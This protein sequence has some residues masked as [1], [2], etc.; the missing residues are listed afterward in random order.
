M[1]N[2]TSPL[3]VAIGAINWDV[4]LFVESLPTPGQEVTVKEVVR[5]PGGTAANVAVAAARLLEPNNVAF[6]GALGDDAIGVGQRAILQSEGVATDGITTIPDT[7]SG[8]AFILVD[9]N[10]QNV[11]ASAL[12]ANALL[13]ADHIRQP[14]VRNM[15][16]SARNCA[17]TDPP[18][19]VIEEIL[20]ITTATDCRVSWDPGVLATADKNIVLPI[21]RRVDT[22]LLNEDETAALL[23]SSDP[24]EISARLRADGWRN[25]IILKQGGQ[26]ATVIDLRHGELMQVPPLPLRDFGMTPVSSVGAGDAFHGALAALEAQGHSP[27]DALLGATTAAG[28]NVSRPG[29]RDA[30]TA[31]ELTQALAAWREMGANVSV[32][33]L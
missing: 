24:R 23:G 21:A 25:R 3:V 32:T 11:I 9:A 5:V 14:V 31:D 27:T 4:T 29:T 15:L 8:Q 26:G 28:I 7:D 33:P 20:Y 19:P 22:L 12:G 10:S 17:I 16:A 18:L 6:I 30:P 2:S 1:T 13:N